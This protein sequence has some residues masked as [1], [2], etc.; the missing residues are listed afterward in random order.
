MLIE[1]WAW[2][3]FLA[4]VGGDTRAE[5]LADRALSLARETDDSKGIAL[6][7]F[8]RNS[9]E[10]WLAANSILNGRR[11]L[12]CQAEVYPQRVLGIFS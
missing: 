10:H 3:G 9:D 4:L 12:I 2:A 7:L 11:T 8:F 1:A 6:S 5:E